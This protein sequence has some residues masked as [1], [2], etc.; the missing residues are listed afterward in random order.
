VFDP[1]HLSSLI[2]SR[3]CHDLISPI[4]AISNGVELMMMDS[5]GASG[6][7]MALILESAGHANARIRYFRV[8]FGLCAPDQRIGRGEVAAI[9]ADN[10]AGGRIAVTWDSPQDL[11]RRDVKMAF[12]GLMCLETALIQ[13]GAVQI[14]LGDMGWQLTARAPRIRRDPSLWDGLSSPAQAGAFY[15]GVAA[16]HVHF[17]LLALEAARQHRAIAMAGGGD[18][19]AE[20]SLRF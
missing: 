2:G 17:P 1:L 16:G 8:A 6:Q 14:T 11:A 5:A 3:I 15:E 19:E 4:G 12:L 13:G 10:A 7:E 20:I 18:G 9:L